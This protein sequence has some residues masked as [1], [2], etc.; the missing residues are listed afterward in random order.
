MKFAIV[1]FAVTAL[2][3]GLI[4]CKRGH[5]DAASQSTVVVFPDAGVSIDVGTGWVRNDMSPGLPV[6]PP[7]L[8]GSAGM[9]RALLFAPSVS[10]LQKA[11]N[12]VRSRFDGDS[13]A[14]KDSYHQESFTA[15]GGLRGQHISYTERT[16]KDGSTTE[17]R[18][19]SYIVQR[20]DGRCV[21][22]SYLAPAE[23]DSDSVRLMIQKSLKLQ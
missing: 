10:D 15:D 20:Q 14:D 1:I 16:Q 9:I 2:A 6:C 3:I 23:T 13:D 19:H 4:G 8:I 18:S 21:T 12:A 17:L 5:G 11:T 7:T 22:I